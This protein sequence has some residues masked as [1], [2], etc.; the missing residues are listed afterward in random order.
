MPSKNEAFARVKIDSLLAAQ[1]WN[2]QDTNAV[3]FEMFTLD[4]QSVDRFVP[5]QKAFTGA[6]IVKP[7]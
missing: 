2:T 7:I 3:H 5:I 4:G 6:S 1:G